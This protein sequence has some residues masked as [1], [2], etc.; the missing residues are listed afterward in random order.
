MSGFEA[1]AHDEFWVWRMR[2][3][4]DQEI[5][6]RFSELTEQAVH[7]GLRHW[8]YDPYGRLAL[9]IVLDQFSRSIWRGTPRA[10][11]QDSMA[12]AVALEGYSNNH[13]DALETPW[14]KTVY[15]LPLSHCEGPDHIDRLDLAITLA[16]NILAEAPP[17]LKHG[18]EFAAQQPVEVRKVIAAFGRH[19]HRNSMLGR[20]SSA[21]EE[22]YLADGRF[23]HLRDI[24]LSGQ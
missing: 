10:F 13:Y 1:R 19:P 12:L 6:A 18:Y 11:S 9:I 24:P 22:V 15:N 8:T 4:A 20:V 5:P 7:D 2:G 14:Y 23:P 21:E 3:G 16:G 17:H